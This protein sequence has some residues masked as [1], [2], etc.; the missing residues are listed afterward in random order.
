MRYEQDEIAKNSQERSF[1]R[2]LADQHTSVTEAA[3]PKDEWSADSTASE[4][5]IKGIEVLS[6]NEY[7]DLVVPFD[8][9]PNKEYYLVFVNYDTGDS[10][11]HHS[12]Q[13]CYLDLF[14]SKELAHDL[15]KKIQEN[16]K[17]PYDYST[18]KK[19]QRLPNSVAYKWDNGQEVDCYAATWKGYFE[20][21]NHVSV[22]SVTVRYSHK[23]K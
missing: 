17:E 21:F 8:V 9:M 3:D 13:I 11:S 6:E 5:Y 14:Q 4:V 22:E 19:G 18:A 10:F 23:Y 7:F 20:R 2:V 1:V 12:G 15:A 16:A